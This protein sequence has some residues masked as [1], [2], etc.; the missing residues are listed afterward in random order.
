MDIS[1]SVKGNWALTEDR[2]HIS[3]HSR[4]RAILLG[5]KMK[6]L[7]KKKNQYFERFL[8]QGATYKAHRTHM[9]LNFL[10]KT[11]ML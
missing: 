2:S 6:F 9:F 11:M 7:V 3:A 10:V 1:G 4:R 5:D 8:K